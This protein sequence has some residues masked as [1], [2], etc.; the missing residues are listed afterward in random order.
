V[1]RS[2][3]DSGVNLRP[4]LPGRRLTPEIYILYRAFRT[5]HK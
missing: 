4:G 1:V 3:I 2:L 5:I